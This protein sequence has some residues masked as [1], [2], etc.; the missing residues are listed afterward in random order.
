MTPALT[1]T[2]TSTVYIEQDSTGF[3]SAPLPSYP[4]TSPA[5][6]LTTSVP[7]TTV[8]TATSTQASIRTIADATGEVPLSESDPA[9]ITINLRAQEGAFSPSSI[10]VP[11]GAEV[12]IVFDNRDV[13]IRHSVVIYADRAA[14]IFKGTAIK[15][16]STTTYTFTAPSTPGKYVLGCGVPTPHRKGDFIVT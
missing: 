5:T 14:P 15:G 2:V 10:T 8:K 7:S 3:P 4:A 1:P 11:A 9:S 13:D 16:P 6:T 12:T